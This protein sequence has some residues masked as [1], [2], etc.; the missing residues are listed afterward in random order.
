MELISPYLTE[1]M[2]THWD[3]FA[4]RYVLTNTTSGPFYEDLSSVDV[5]ILEEAASSPETSQKACLAGPT[6]ISWRHESAYMICRLDTVMRL[7]REPDPQPHWEIK[8]VITSGW[9]LKRIDGLLMKKKFLV[10]KDPQTSDLINPLISPILDDN[11]ARRSTGIKD[12]LKST[13][14]PVYAR[15]NDLAQKCK[16]LHSPLKMSKLHTQSSLVS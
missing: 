13:I 2:L 3:N 8:T 9:P 5:T 14:T 16:V 11:Y 6:C 1:S 10:V 7:G 15:S 12:I 4:S